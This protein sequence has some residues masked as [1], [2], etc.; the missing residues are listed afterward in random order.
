MC[1]FLEVNEFYGI[2]DEVSYYRQ[3]KA[4]MNI[5]RPA[6]EHLFYEL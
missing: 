1:A 6:G 4:R 3:Y 2:R 5:M